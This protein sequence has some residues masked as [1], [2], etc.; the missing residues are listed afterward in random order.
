MRVLIKNNT[1]IQK[2]I[3][4]FQPKLP[5]FRCDYELSQ[6][7]AAGLSIEL[8]I[9]FEGTEN[10]EFA[11][12]IKILTDDDQSYELPLLAFSSMAKIIFE[13]LVNLGFIQKG[14]VKTE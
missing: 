13:P 12:S 14:K 3:R 9:S 4:V 1:S 8:L 5:C 10:G 6:S 2:R 11:D 7:I